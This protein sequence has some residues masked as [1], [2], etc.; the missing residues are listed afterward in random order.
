MLKQLLLAGSALALISTAHADVVGIRLGTYQWQQDYD[1]DIR[2]GGDRVD[3]HEDL[4]I[5][6]DDGNVVYF[7]VEHP[8]PL[9]PNLLLQRT[10][11]AVRNTEQVR[12]NFTFD[13]NVYTA[14]ES[15]SADVDLSHTDAT[16]YYELLDNVVSLDAGLTLR[17][18][19]EGI[20]LHSASGL[21]GQV[22]IDAVLPMVYLAGRMNLPFTGLYVGAE[23]NGI[24][25]RDASLFDAR[26][27]IGYETRI[28]LGVELG[29]RTFDLDYD[30]DDD[31]ANL[32][33]D[34]AYGSLFYHF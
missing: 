6:N 4:G 14:N 31:E 19:D 10:N 28:G 25:Y 27:S 18:F 16:F 1:G 12:R 11:L 21:R 26:I 20:E 32:T 2:S 17:W 5:D 13:S 22:D 8:L 23:A 3:L 7:A 24:A 34:G 15:V 33:V 9:V 29:Y 30:D